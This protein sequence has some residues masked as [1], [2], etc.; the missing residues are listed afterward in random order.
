LIISRVIPVE[1]CLD[2]GRGQVND[3]A[4]AREG[5]SAFYAC[6]KL[7]TFVEVNTFAGD[8]EH[9]PRMVA[10]WWEDHR[11][12]ILFFHRDQESPGCFGER[13]L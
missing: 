10:E 5:A 8:G 1:T 7:V 11:T 2:G 3:D 13:L 4:N 6:G 12:V 9:V